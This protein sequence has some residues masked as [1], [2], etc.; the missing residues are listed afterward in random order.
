MWR[1]WLIDIIEGLLW[2]SAGAL[3]YWLLWCLQ[4]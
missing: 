3:T 2:F 4:L 1:D